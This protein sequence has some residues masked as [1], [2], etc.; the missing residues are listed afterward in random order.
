V[1]G[2]WVGR[3][4][5][6]ERKQGHSC[7]T[8]GNTCKRET[9]KKRVVT[10]RYWK[11]PAEPLLLFASPCHR[12]PP[13][14]SFSSH[15]SQVRYTF[16]AAA[17]VAIFDVSAALDAAATAAAPPLYAHHSR[18]LSHLPGSPPLP[19]PPS[20]RLPFSRCFTPPDPLLSLPLPLFP[21]SPAVC[22]PAYP[23][24]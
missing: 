10:C 13:P 22:M 7:T 3:A 24:P 21:L 20:G 12:P 19:V 18:R 23:S 4:H 6:S 1:R 15:D 14:H 2:R 16:H 8:R 17:V 11:R 5:A 9:K